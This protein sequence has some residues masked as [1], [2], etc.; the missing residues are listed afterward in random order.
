M[1]TSPPPDHVVAQVLAG[2]PELGPELGPGHFHVTRLTGGL[3]HHSLA[4]TTLAGEFV[5]QRVHPIFAPEVHHNIAAVTDHLQRR[6][7]PAP[8]LLT[9]HT[10]TCWQDLGEHGI[11]RAMTRL[12]GR[13]FAAPVSAAQAYAAGAAVGAFHAGLCDLEYTFQAVR[14]GVH[15]TA[16]HLKNLEDAVATGREHRLF[17]EV[18][19]LAAEIFAGVTTL[20]VLDGLPLRVGHGDLKF[21][22][23][24]FRGDT[25]TDAAVSTGIVDLDTVGP[26]PLH[27]ELGDAWRSWCHSGGEDQTTAHF[28]LE[29]FAASLA[30]Y[31]TTAPQITVAEQQALIHGVEW[32]SLELAARFAADALRERYFGWDPARFPAAGEH[33]LLRARGQW[34]LHRATLATRKARADLFADVP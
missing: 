4:V 26:L 11:W 14:T 1:P 5:V 27:H 23:L 19:A 12:P 15:D 28:D 21:S 18:S 3:I 25:P 22:N 8:R 33:H 20:P 17:A 7:L 9:S 13:S 10:G 24:L 16:A 34:A 32:I 30:G 29:I 31:K 6:G 2:F